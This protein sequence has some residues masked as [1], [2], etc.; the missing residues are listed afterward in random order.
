MASSKMEFKF[1]WRESNIL[2]P[3]L[4][5]N[6]VTLQLIF[7]DGEEAFVRWTRSDS[8]YG[9]RN[10]AKVWQGT[11]YTYRDLSWRHSMNTILLQVSISWSCS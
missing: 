6:E 1:S 3:S 4:Q 2:A 10:L 11:P 5:R 8:T 7:F 9:S